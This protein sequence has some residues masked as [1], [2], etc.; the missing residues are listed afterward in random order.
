MRIHT[1]ILCLGLQAF[2]PL[3]VQAGTPLLKS[4]FE[5][6]SQTYN[7]WGGVDPMGDIHLLG[8]GQL[9]VNDSGAIGNNNFSP[10][11]AVGDLNG[12][13]L[14]DIVMADTRG[15]IWYF[16]NH[17]TQ[18]QPKFTFGEVL[19]LWFGSERIRSF[20]RSHAV[21]PRIQ[22]VDVDG[23]GKLDLLVG[24][25]EGRLFYV[26]NDGSAQLPVFSMP[27][28]LDEL[29]IK[30]STSGLPWCNYF[31]PYLVDWFKN[32]TRYLIMGDGT[33]SANSIYMLKDTGNKLKPEF[34]DADR[35]KIIP[36][37]GR[38]QLTPQ[39]VDWNA[40]GKPD[41]LCGE[42]SGYIN[43]FL[44]TSNAAD[45]TPSFDKGTRITLGGR[46]IFAPFS[47]PCVADLNNNHLPNLLL[48]APDGKISYARNTGTSGQPAFTDAP[49]L[50]KGTN[51]YPP[52]LIPND[53]KFGTPYGDSYNLMVVTNAEVEPG[54]TLP[55]DHVG[56]NALKSYVFP[57]SNT[58]FKT[59]YF[60]NPDKEID[61]FTNPNEHYMV[62]D[63]KITLQEGRQYPY[64]FYVLTNGVTDLRVKLSGVEYNNATKGH[65]DFD[66]VKPFGG[67]GAWTKITDTFSWTSH[68]GQKGAT[69][70]F[71]FSIRWHGEGT[72]YVDDIVIDSE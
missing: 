14:P 2:A 17:G 63:S 16:P 67:S 43:I 71:D 54:F 64:S 4:D 50:L 60:V 40:D 32:G 28:E 11:I 36:G 15:F 18:T 37:M 38:E 23:D 31:S 33:Y 6:P 21:V 55:P 61:S 34:K 25:F 3:W 59:R 27:Q 46:N 41:I 49:T 20:P 68:Y 51:P 48:P 35:V 8:E 1:A 44:N 72:I 53:W 10:G 19:P 13:G 70:A 29:D 24:T 9:A 12:D 45:P 39:V 62:Y 58:Y 69:T 56:K 47:V 66:I 7:P 5:S 26:H 42:R 52:I 65:V 30:T 57:F 22:L